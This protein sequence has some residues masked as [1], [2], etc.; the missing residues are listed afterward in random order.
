MD[1]L[2]NATVYFPKHCKYCKQRLGKPRCNV[3]QIECEGCGEYF[4]V[5][6][7]K[8]HCPLS[9]KCEK[10]NM[11]GQY[12]CGGNFYSKKLCDYCYI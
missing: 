9:V 7:Y 1:F 5:S 2:N 4:C 10:C 3:G 8:E 6:C 11:E 12:R